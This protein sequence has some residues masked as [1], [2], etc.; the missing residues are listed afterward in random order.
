MLDRQR[1]SRILEVGR[2][3]VS[4]LEL[5]TLLQRVLDEARALTGARYAALGILDESR[6][7]LE[8]F[9]TVGIDPAA[10]A[11]IGDLPRGRG[12]LGVLISDPE[13]LRLDDVGDH[14]RSYG[15]PLDHP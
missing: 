7:E 4:E 6:T 9:L 3:V 14:P 12:V 13:P 15:F 10:H 8:R 5:E 2:S 1:L 11:A